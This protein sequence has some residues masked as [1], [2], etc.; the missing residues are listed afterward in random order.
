MNL[1]TKRIW[2]YECKCEVFMDPAPAVP[3]YDSDQEIEG[4]TYKS[5]DS[6]HGSYSTLRTNT[7]ERTN[8]FAFEKTVGLNVGMSGDASD[9]SDGED[10]SDYNV[11]R[12][13]GLVGLQNIGNTCYMNAALQALS[14]AVPLTRFFLECA[15][16]VQILSEGKKPGLSR[17]YQTL[18]RDMWKKNGGYVTPSGKKTRKSLWQSRDGVCRGRDFVRDQERPSHVQGLL[19]ARHPRVSQE[20]YGSAARRAETSGAARDDL[21]E[22]FRYF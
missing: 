10:S 17:T 20:F 1:L 3:S 14:N 4:C 21:D 18:V 16:T 22:R 8:V 9:G 12:P 7:P 2:C 13:V 6:G 15:T 11:D 19:P 5:R